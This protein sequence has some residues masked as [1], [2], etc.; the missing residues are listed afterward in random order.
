MWCGVVWCGVVM[1]HAANASLWLRAVL[2]LR[3]WIRGAG[4][5]VAQYSKWAL[6]AGIIAFKFM[7]W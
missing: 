2:A 1:R 5:A 4:F 3:R 7:E 6:L